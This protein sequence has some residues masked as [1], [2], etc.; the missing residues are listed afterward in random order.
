MWKWSDFVQGGCGEAGCRIF[1]W[2]ATYRYDYEPVVVVDA[3]FRG[4][5]LLE[6]ARAGTRNLLFV[7]RQM[8]VEK[9]SCCRG[10]ID[11]LK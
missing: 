7:V 8:F 11:F 6:P 1:E 9:V 10:W 5:F 4:C 3:E 2:T